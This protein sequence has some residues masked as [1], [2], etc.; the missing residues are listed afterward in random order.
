[1]RCECLQKLNTSW[2]VKT[3]EEHLTERVREVMTATLQISPTRMKMAATEEVSIYTA[4]EPKI[5]SSK[6]VAVI[7]DEVTSE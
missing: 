2:S 5:P 3:V 1:M 7:I 4:I 6:V